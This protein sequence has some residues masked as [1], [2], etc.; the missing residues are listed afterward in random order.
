MQNGIRGVSMIF[1]TEVKIECGITWLGDDW[2]QQVMQADC[3]L[4]FVCLC[5]CGW[6]SVSCRDWLYLG[7]N[8]QFPWIFRS[9]KRK[10]KCQPSLNIHHDALSSRHVARLFPKALVIPFMPNTTASLHI[11]VSCSWFFSSESD[12]EEVTKSLTNINWWP[13]GYIGHHH[14]NCTQCRIFNASL[15][16]NLLSDIWS[17]K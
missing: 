11:E 5:F 9:K 16:V 14:A 7:V 10:K 3:R 12:S 8:V 13:V 17:L 15:H 2:Q 6:L 4:L 1:S